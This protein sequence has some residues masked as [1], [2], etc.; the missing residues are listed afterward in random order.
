MM[1]DAKIEDCL[2]DI[3]AISELLDVYIEHCTGEPVS[4]DCFVFLAKMLRKKILKINNIL[5]EKE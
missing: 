5:M 2:I 4:L 1:I 3:T